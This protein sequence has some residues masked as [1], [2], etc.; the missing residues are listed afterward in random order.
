MVPGNQQEPWVTRTVTSCGALGKPFPL[1][2]ER[3]EGHL[4]GRNLPHCPP[5][6]VAVKVAGTAGHS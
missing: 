1:P 2:G 4:A 5:P 6:A 3:S